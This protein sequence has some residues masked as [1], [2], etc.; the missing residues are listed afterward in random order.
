MPKVGAEG[1]EEEVEGADVDG[2]EHGDEAEQVEPG[3]EPAGEAV[4]EDRAPVVEAAGG[5]IGRG[6]L[7]QRQREDAR[8]SRQPIGQPMPMAAPP[9]P[10]VAWPSELMP[11]DRMQMI[12]NEIAKFEKRPIGAPVPARSPSRGEP[13]GPPSS[14]FRCSWRSL[15]ELLGITGVTGKGRPIAAAHL[16]RRRARR[17]K[18]PCRA[19]PGDE[20]DHGVASGAKRDRLWRLQPQ[21]QRATRHHPTCPCAIFISGLLRVC[22]LNRR[23]PARAARSRPHPRARRRAVN[24]RKW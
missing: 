6:D 2:A 22:K 17:A 16:S 21:S 20:W 9:A 15:W 13:S 18:P 24:P 23:G 19:A 5:R 3:R 10:A 7:R 8:R 1:A 11:P 4:P 12:E 14:G